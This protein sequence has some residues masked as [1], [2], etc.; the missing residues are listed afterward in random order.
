MKWKR[1]VNS[2]NYKSSTYVGFKII[3]T[4]FLNWL[5][6]GSFCFACNTILMLQVFVAS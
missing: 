4:K 1:V 5:K 3:S 6:K 2:N